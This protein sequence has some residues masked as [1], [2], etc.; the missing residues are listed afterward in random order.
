MNTEMTERNRLIRAAY[1]SGVSRRAL[2]QH[3]GISPQRVM[4]IV[5]PE[6]ERERRRRARQRK[7]ETP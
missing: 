1:S 2:A 3:F 4:Q 5:N 7:K 6:P